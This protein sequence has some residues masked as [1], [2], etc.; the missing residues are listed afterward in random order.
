MPKIPEQIS[1]MFSN[2]QGKTDANLAQDSNNLGGIPAEDWATKEWVKNYH[3]NKEEELRKY[4]DNQDAKILSEAKEFANSLGRGQ[5]F[6]SFAKQSDLTALETKLNKKITEGDTEQKNYTDTQLKK[7][8]ED[9]NANFKDTGDTLKTLN[10]GI[11]NLQAKDNVIDKEIEALKEK[12]KALNNSI[13]NNSSSIGSL[14][15]KYDQLFQSVSDGKSKIA[16]AITGKGVMTSAD[17][18]FDVMAANIRSIPTG[19]GEI[20]PPGYIDTSSGTA[21]ASDIK[22]GKI[23]FSQGNMIIG[24]HIEEGYNTSDA[25]ATAADILEGKTAYT[26]EGRVEGT[27]KLSSEGGLE[28]SYTADDVTKIFGTKENGIQ[29]STIGYKTDYSEELPEGDTGIPDIGTF[30]MQTITNIN[31]DIEKVYGFSIHVKTKNLLVHVKNELGYFEIESKYTFEQLGIED[32]GRNLTNKNIALG[33][34]SFNITQP[35]LILVKDDGETFSKSILTPYII[36]L[37]LDKETKKITLKTDSVQ[38]FNGIEGRETDYN[39]SNISI[40]ENIKGEGNISFLVTLKFQYDTRI[41]VAYF[42]LKKSS[43]QLMLYRSSVL[44]D[45]IYLDGFT[46]GATLINPYVFMLPIWDKSIDKTP[47]CTIKYGIIYRGI[48]E[49]ENDIPIN[50]EFKLSELKGNILAVAPNGEKYLG[51]DVEIENPAESEEKQNYKYKFWIVDVSFD[52][53]NQTVVGNDIT[54]ITDITFP[55]ILKGNVMPHGF[56]LSDN[57]LVFHIKDPEKR[58]VTSTGIKNY[59]TYFYNVTFDTE[60]H[61]SLIDY[62]P[63]YDWGDYTRGFKSI[64][65]NNNEKWLYYYHISSKDHTFNLISAKRDFSRIIGLLYQGET[66][67]KLDDKMLN[68]LP[69][70]VKAG[71]K[72]IGL[73]NVVEE[74]TM[75]V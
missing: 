47:K 30:I 54:Y 12:D 57:L 36:P 75:E 72:F 10:N 5:D 59:Y 19:G 66:Y 1:K 71:K 34:T 16:G 46:E 9:V 37:N 58:G 56:F 17:S 42:V 23:A 11:A 69:G 35:Y 49:N 50:S 27:L 6:S 55:D 67:Y 25:T 21:L 40:L 68:A 24:T 13:S 60:Y 32:G 28:P 4:I 2:S 43:S 65:R 15:T 26:S 14:N 20:I 3:G 70:D 52:Y 7:V 18:S 29:V 64:N 33:C 41:S 63:S 44:E 8:V 62:M 53:K 51:Y 61:F 48:T 38:R 74:G 31:G 22:L 39:I 73:S 45:V